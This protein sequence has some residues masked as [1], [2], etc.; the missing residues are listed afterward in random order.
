MCESFVSTRDVLLLLGCS[1]TI[2]RM[3]SNGSGHEAA[4]NAAGRLIAKM[5]SKISR[6]EAANLALTERTS[7][8]PAQQQPIERL[9]IAITDVA[10][11]WKES[12]CRKF[13]Y[14]EPPSCLGSAVAPR[15]VR[16]Q[17]ESIDARAPKLLAYIADAAD[18]YRHIGF[19][20]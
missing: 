8:G 6:L 19:S 5:R 18:S 11:R 12:L 10:R 2:V 3:S 17:L 4:R 16:E 14:G 9:E 1:A 20:E 13:C 7:S 15:A